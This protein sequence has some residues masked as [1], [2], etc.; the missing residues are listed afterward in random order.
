MCSPVLLLTLCCM[1]HCS[2]SREHCTHLLFSLSLT[3]I[4]WLAAAT[5]LTQALGG[6]LNCNIIEDKFVYCGHLNAMEGFAWLI[7]FVF[8]LTL[9]GNKLTIVYRLMLTL[10]LFFVA[11][12]GI[13]G[14]RRGDEVTA[15][16]VEVWAKGK[17]PKYTKVR[18]CYHFKS[19]FFHRGVSM[20][21]KIPQLCSD[22][23]SFCC[24]VFTCRSYLFV[25]HNSNLEWHPL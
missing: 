2:L 9:Q 1:S 21:S 20:R 13:L 5:A 18:Y 14:A 23:F 4:F 22:M 6:A 24:F 15:P 3:W 17:R 7:W 10:M 8:L 11:I 19:A 25:R 16:M 12:R